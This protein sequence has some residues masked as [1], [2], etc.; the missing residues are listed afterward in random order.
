[1]VLAFNNF[2]QNNYFDLKKK[3]A[4][5]ILKFWSNKLNL[6]YFSNKKKKKVQNL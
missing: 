4:K 2:L 1:M 3:K 5:H 6:S